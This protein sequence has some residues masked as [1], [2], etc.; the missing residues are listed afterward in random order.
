MRGRWFSRDLYV[1]RTLELRRASLHV[2]FDQRSI[3]IDVAGAQ[4]RI[5]LR[6]VRQ[7]VELSRYL[8][9]AA[10]HGVQAPELPHDA[11]LG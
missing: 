11:F 9:A 8:C 2:D 7:P 5:D 10:S 6:A 1:A 4:L 3:V